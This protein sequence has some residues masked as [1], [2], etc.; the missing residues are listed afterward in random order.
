MGTRARAAAQPS[1]LVSI[2]P[3]EGRLHLGNSSNAARRTRCPLTFG[4]GINSDTRS[5]SMRGR[6]RM[7][8]WQLPLALL[9]GLSTLC[10]ST[11]AASTRALMASGSHVYQLH[12]KIKLFA[13]KV[14]PFG[15]RAPTPLSQ[16]RAPR[17][18]VARA[19]APA[20]V[21]ADPWSLRCAPSAEM[22]LP[23]PQPLRRIS[24]TTCR[25]ARQPPRNTR[26]R[27]WARSWRATGW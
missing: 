24:S 16:A 27:V 19:L 1:E 9:L 11:T 6:A 18:C 4:R 20:H 7:S 12:D 23:A 25:S 22:A 8:P 13:N 3:V 14:G 26:R 2:L 5:G 21:P 15:S 17:L 10:C